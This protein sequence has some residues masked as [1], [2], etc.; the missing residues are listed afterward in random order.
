VSP[1]ARLTAI[2]KA[3]VAFALA[4]P[5]HF[6]LMFRSELVH[7]ERHAD[8][9]ACAQSAFDV[10]VAVVNDVSPCTRSPA[11][12][13]PRVLAAWSLAHGLASLLIEGKLDRHFGKGKQ[14]RTA[15]AETVLTAFES[16]IG[17]RS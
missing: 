8:A 2:G 7:Q 17:G 15:A 16:M 5:A 13:T 12:P 11:Q 1:R 4:H 10:L 9:E 6:K 14:A 3:Y